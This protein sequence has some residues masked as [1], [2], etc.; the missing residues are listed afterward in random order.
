VSA[1]ELFV[2]SI[3]PGYVRVTV[4][5][6]NACTRETGCTV[7]AVELQFLGKKSTVSA[8]VSHSARRVPAANGLAGG[9]VNPRKL[10]DRQ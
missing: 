10:C 2:E 1:S 4:T 7:S 3:D 8:R 6:G 5:G 9:L